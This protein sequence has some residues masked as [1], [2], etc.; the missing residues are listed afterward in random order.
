MDWFVAL[1]TSSLVEFS[2]VSELHPIEVALVGVASWDRKFMFT[3]ELEFLFDD[4]KWFLRDFTLYRPIQD[5][6][7]DIFYVLWKF[8]CRN[9]FIYF[10]WWGFVGGPIKYRS[11]MVIT[12]SVSDVVIF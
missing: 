8:I 10:G 9:Y 2:R 12:R 5:I 4:S 1:I 7:R 6:I 11:S 3:V